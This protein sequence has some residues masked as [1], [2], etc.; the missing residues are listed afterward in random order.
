LLTGSLYF[1]GTIGFF[2][3]WIF[4]WRIYRELRVD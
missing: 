2:A 1:A 3:S 4:V